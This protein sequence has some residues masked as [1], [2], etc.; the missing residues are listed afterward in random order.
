MLLVSQKATFNVAVTMID[1]SRLVNYLLR[2][3]FTLVLSTGTMLHLAVRFS[4][5][6]W[7]N[8]I[9]ARKRTVSRGCCNEEDWLDRSVAEHTCL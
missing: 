7:F 3:A 2:L 1:I 6:M 9:V 8:V 4:Q 5:E